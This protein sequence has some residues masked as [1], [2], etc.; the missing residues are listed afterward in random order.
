MNHGIVPDPVAHRWDQA[1]E[2][3]VLAFDDGGRLTAA[4]L[5]DVVAERGGHLA[6]RLPD[7]GRRVAIIEPN[8]RE[9]V[10]AI[11]ACIRAGAVA[12][13]LDPDL[14]ASE[15]DAR[16]AAGSIDRVILG[17]EV[18]V[19]PGALGVSSIN[20]MGHPKAPPMP[21]SPLE[22]ER[23]LTL[24]F[25]SGTEG[26]PTPVVHTAWNHAAAAIASAQRLGVNAEDRWYDPLGLFHMGGLAPVTRGLFAGMPVIISEDVGS[27]G[28]F[29]RIAASAG[30][31]ASVVPTMVAQE[32][33]RG[34][35]SPATVRCLLVGGAPL[36][37]ELF[38]RARAADLPV[39][40]SYGLT[41]TVGQVATATPPERSSHPGTVG[42]PLPGIGVTVRRDGVLADPE[43][44][45]V[46]EVSGPTVVPEGDGAARAAPLVTN[47]RGYRDPE[48]RLWVV[49]RVDD[50]IV[51]GGVV[52]HA[53]RIREVIEGDPSV[54][55]AAVVGVA[56]DT[57]GERV[58][59]AVLVRDDTVDP[60]VLLERCRHELETA[61]VP[62]HL[63]LV[64][65]LP[66]TASGT[67]DREALRSRLRGTREV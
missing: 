55:E 54:V 24:L 8:R 53:H 49:G 34:A 15:R 64:T 29:D 26:E 32:L 9:A 12:A 41:E 62:R 44:V 25:T 36:R 31:I 14:S 35:T 16:L 65:E 57:W 51:T 1:P 17:E 48:G 2:A 20:S 63:E 30:A 56:D 58:A 33:D 43:E 67:V 39:W 50:A 19:E 18:S 61:A 22:P 47:D 66:R 23:P 5:E 60:E 28:L 7:R 40:P 10:I 52:V 45:G 21:A 13:P 42:R 4:Q 59:A 27:D 6:D 3:E 38:E 37:D 46:I 11:L